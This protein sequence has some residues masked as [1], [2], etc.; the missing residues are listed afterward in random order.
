VRGG[1]SVRET[2]KRVRLAGQPKARPRR[3][4]ID[5]D[6]IAALED[7]GDALEGAIGHEV[8]VRQRGE[9]IVAELRFDEVRDAHALAREL[10]RRSG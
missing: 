6:V 3:A 1:W 8:T 10:R 7:V 4:A 5:P 9:G 2:E